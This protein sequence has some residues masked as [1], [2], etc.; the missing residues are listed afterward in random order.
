MDG[1]SN[2]ALGSQRDKRLVDLIQSRMAL[3]TEQVRVIAFKDM[4][5]GRRKA[6]ERL[7]KL[8]ARQRVKR[9]RLAPNE[10]YIYFIG[11]R[12]GRLEHLIAINWIYIW[13]EHGL[14][15]WETL[16]RW[17]Y[18]FDHGILQADGFAVIKNTVTDDLRFLFIEMDRSD[19]EFDKVG[20]YNDLYE[21]ENYSWWGQYAK[22]FPPV[23]VVTTSMARLKRIQEAIG[24]DNRNG[25]QFEVY[26][27]DYIREACSNENY[28]ILLQSK[29]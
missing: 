25:L 12:H 19:N 8:C 18:E 22:R 11:K 28:N 9:L 29:G 15:G 17:E 4:P 1:L 2:H 10:P 24:R 3:D 14:K 16:Q 13:V 5:S 26:P 20:K 7:Q 6:Q 23:L 21:S 27:L